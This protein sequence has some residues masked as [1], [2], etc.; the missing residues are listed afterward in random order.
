MRVN[1][2]FIV[3]KRDVSNERE[4]LDLLL[5]CYRRLVLLDFPIE[6]A[7]FDLTQGTDRFETT[8]GQVLCLCN[9]FE[10]FENLVSRVE[11]DDEGF[12]V[13]SNLL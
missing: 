2:W 7:E 5:K 1:L 11:D 12:R 8:A 6:P 3:F 9:G 13:F 4:Q 10:L